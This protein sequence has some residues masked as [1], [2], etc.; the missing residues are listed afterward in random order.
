MLMF[1][2]IARVSVGEE[3]GHN[4]GS[5]CIITHVHVH[6]F[7]QSMS[8]FNDNPFCSIYEESP[9]DHFQSVSGVIL[10]SST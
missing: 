1:L 3:V 9:Q 5:K 6:V 4:V 7:I 2:V 8:I 10:F